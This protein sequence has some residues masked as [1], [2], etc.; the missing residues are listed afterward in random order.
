M[1][2]VPPPAAIL[3]KIV[4]GTAGEASGNVNGD[5]TT[6]TGATGATGE[7]T[8]MATIAETTAAGAMT[9]I[10]TSAGIGEGGV[11]TTQMMSGGISAETVAT[12]TLM[13][14]GVID[15]STST[16]VNTAIATAMMTMTIEA[17]PETKRSVL[18]PRVMVMVGGPGAMVI[19][20]ARTGKSR[21]CRETLWM[22]LIPLN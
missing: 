7:T 17:A 6:A 4:S 11:L 22:M 3:Q 13:T 10:T 15:E 18:G 12:T 19:V 20:T 14:S 21:L 16:R 1:K 5:M 2:I 8:A 9:A